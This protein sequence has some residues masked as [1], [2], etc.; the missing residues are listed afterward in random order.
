ML[1][2]PKKST[3]DQAVVFVFEAKF[4]LEIKAKPFTAVSQCLGEI[5]LGARRS[6]E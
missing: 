2:P 4:Q 3:F 6:S 5:Q 1:L